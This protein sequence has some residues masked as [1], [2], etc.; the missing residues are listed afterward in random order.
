M[1]TGNWDILLQRL[2]LEMGN[3]EYIETSSSSGIIRDLCTVDIEMSLYK[4]FIEYKAEKILLH[5]VRRQIDKKDL[6]GTQGIPE[7]IILVTMMLKKIS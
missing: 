6:K 1:V 3:L 5:R 2:R 7:V 4:I